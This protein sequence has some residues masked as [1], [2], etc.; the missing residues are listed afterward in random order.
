MLMAI[1][2][3]GARV[4]HD[5]LDLRRMAEIPIYEADTLLGFEQ[6]RARRCLCEMSE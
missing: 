5:G 1:A 2:D 3:V 4:S 6:R